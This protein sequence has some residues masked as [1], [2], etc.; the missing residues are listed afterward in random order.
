MS[1]GRTTRSRARQNALDMIWT[2][3]VVFA[4]VLPLWF[5]GQASP[6]DSK[7]IRPIDPTPAYRA[8]VAS[9]KGPV[10]STLPDGW[11]ATVADG[12]T[13]EGVYRVGYVV[14][15]HY[16]EWQGST[17]TEFLKEATGRGRRTGTTRVGN[18]MW[19]T[20][21]NRDGAESLVLRRGTVTVLVGGVRETASDEELRQLAAAV[22]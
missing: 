22:R 4:I 5:F 3:V 2:L 21:E 18:A 17:G 11:V 10:P 6:E 9:A 15:D 14:G 7:R 12:V 20:W 13:T 1:T 16:L 19:E 8:Y